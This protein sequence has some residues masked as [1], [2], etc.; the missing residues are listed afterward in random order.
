MSTELSEQMAILMDRQ[1]AILKEYMDKRFA[2]M[3]ENL[4]KTNDN[5]QQRMTDIVERLE[6]RITDNEAAVKKVN[7]DR[8]K[9]KSTIESD[10][11]GYQKQ[12]H[13]TISENNKKLE[14][15]LTEKI[16]EFMES[17]EVF[18]ETHQQYCDKMESLDR[19]V[20]DYKSCIGVQIK[21]CEKMIS[22]ALEQMK[23]LKRPIR[24][25]SDAQCS[26]LK[27][28]EEIK[29]EEIPQESL[30][31]S[32]LVGRGS[33]SEANVTKTRKRP[34]DKMVDYVDDDASGQGYY[35]SDNEKYESTLEHQETATCCQAI[36]PV[37]SHGAEEGN[38]DKCESYGEPKSAR[39]VRNVYGIRAKGRLKRDCKMGTQPRVKI[40]CKACGSEMHRIRRCTN[41]VK[42]KCYFDQLRGVGKVSQSTDNASQSINDSGVNCTTNSSSENI[43]MNLKF[44]LKLSGYRE[45]AEFFRFSTNQ[46]KSKYDIFLPKSSTSAHTPN[47]DY[48]A[49]SSVDAY[50][51][52]DYLSGSNMLDNKNTE[53]NHSA[54]SSP[55]LDFSE[56]FVETGKTETTLHKYVDDLSGLVWNCKQNA[57]S[58]IMVDS[59]H[60]SLPASTN[61]S[62]AIGD[63]YGFFTEFESAL[64]SFS[65]DTV[66]RSYLT[67]SD[68]LSALA[69]NGM[70]LETKDWSQEILNLKSELLRKD[71][72]IAEL[73]MKVSEST[74]DVYQLQ[75]ELGKVRAYLETKLATEWREDCFQADQTY[76]ALSTK[77]M[78]QAHTL[79]VKECET[80]QRSQLSFEWDE[81]DT[82]CYGSGSY[83]L[84]KSVGSC[85]S[86]LVGDNTILGYVSSP[87]R[88]SR[89]SRSGG[90]YDGT[91]SDIS[92]NPAGSVDGSQASVNNSRVGPVK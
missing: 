82:S 18:N 86:S 31:H 14:T 71:I 45:I 43:S 87:S 46:D 30:E 91:L 15:A 5:L 56:T 81:G 12:I 44:K 64:D 51:Y 83:Q 11:K 92:D 40:V 59:E 23:E 25:V 24:N 16:N 32:R 22:D 28:L 60:D 10:I 38:R 76:S 49:V 1:M 68:K 65:A 8:E 72:V 63:S 2:E 48:V 39:I 73:E 74:A 84:Y 50:G 79:L 53:Q 34:P 89:S 54:E 85:H 57:T 4:G 37:R 62:D 52:I 3:N 27:D 77:V 80:N 41:A 6:S 29:D 78:C 90:R 36:L 66:N 17:Q 47:K 7:E 58:D 20:K 21:N 69:D 13:D 35:L 75:Q 55:L 67:V 70:E 61:D 26:V 33:Y 19:E 9:D 42:V 88:A